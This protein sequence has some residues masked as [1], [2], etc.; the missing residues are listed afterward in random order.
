MG[1]FYYW[2]AQNLRAKNEEQHLKRLALLGD[3]RAATQ[4]P[5]KDFSKYV[6]QLER[7]FLQ[8]N[9][10]AKK[11]TPPEDLEAKLGIKIRNKRK[12]IPSGREK[13]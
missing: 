13:I 10:N 3:L 8:T 4:Y 9:Q 1:V 5:Q 2:H 11:P 6:K 12:R 7:N